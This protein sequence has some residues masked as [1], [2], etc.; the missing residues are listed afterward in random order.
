MH[1]GDASG[2]IPSTFRIARQILSRIED[3]NTGEILARGSVVTE[4]P[5]RADHRAASGTAEM[6]GDVAAKFPFLDGTKPVTDDPTEQLL[7]RTWQPQLEITGA[8]GLPPC[9]RAGNVLRA[10]TS[11]YLS[12]RLPPTVEPVEAS[13]GLDRSSSPATRRTAPPSATAPT[14]HSTGMER[15]GVRA[16][17]GDVA[18]TT[19]RLAAF[20]KPARAMGE[21][22]SISFMGMLGHR[23]PEAQFVVT[24]VLGPG[25]NAHGPE[26]VPPRPDR[27][28]ADRSDRNGAPRPRQSG[29]VRTSTVQAPDADVQKGTCDD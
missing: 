3:E 20:G 25:S 8:D 23:F 15:A 16:V 18:Q 29:V 1:S 9:D 22:G 21:G 26:R 14:R 6:S 2:V 11:L 5:D 19:R 27:A 13:E 17:A 7:N 28:Q 12:L 10:I 24:G 4:I